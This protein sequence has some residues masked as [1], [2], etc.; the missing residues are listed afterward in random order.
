M[1]N[2]FKERLESAGPLTCTKGNLG[3]M[4]MLFICQ[5]G[6]DFSCVPFR[7]QSAESGASPLDLYS[8]GR[9][10]CSQHLDQRSKAL[11]RVCRLVC[12][13]MAEPT[14]REGEVVVEIK[15]SSPF[16]T[17]ETRDV[18][19]YEGLGC[20][21]QPCSSRRFMCI[22]LVELLSF[23]HKRRRITELPGREPPMWKETHKDHEDAQDDRKE[24][25]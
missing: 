19:N 23:M 20:E 4:D 5:R 25:K 24:T 12:H 22:L 17:S 2:Q 18:F 9:V 8:C 7:A 1:R 10:L 6:F 13:G 15:W 3:V 21:T 16:S 14:G 11:H